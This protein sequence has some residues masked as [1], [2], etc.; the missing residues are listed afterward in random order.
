MS[1]TGVFLAISVQSCVFKASMIV[2][3]GS[4]Q[5]YK[6]RSTLILQCSHVSCLALDRRFS[7][8]AGTAD[9]PIILVLLFAFLTSFS[10]PPW[11]D[12]PTYVRTA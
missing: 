2:T 10:Q 9:L 1:M 8:V 7:A 3:S 11:I 5:Y 12:N 6:E 4:E